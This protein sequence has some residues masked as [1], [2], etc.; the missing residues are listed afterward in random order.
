MSTRD[1]VD[2]RLC[3]LYMGNRLGKTC[4]RTWTFVSGVLSCTFRRLFT[5]IG[6]CRTKSRTSSSLLL[7]SNKGLQVKVIL[8]RALCS[9]TVHA[10]VGVPFR[11]TTSPL[12]SYVW[13]YSNSKYPILFIY[14]YLPGSSFLHRL[15]TFLQ[16]SSLLLHQLILSFPDFS[17]F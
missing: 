12:R 13:Y 15:V 1:P 2:T 8:Y 4:I 17:L 7:C 16:G 10:V 14:P 11:S 5:T 9:N 3:L 6:T